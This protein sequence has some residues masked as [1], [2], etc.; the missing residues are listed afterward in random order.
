MTAW[1]IHAISWRSSLLCLL[2]AYA[3]MACS[4]PEPTPR[5]STDR[6]PNFIVIMADDQGYGEVGCFGS[7]RGT[8]PR[9]DRMAAEG[10]RFTQFYAAPACGPA[11]ASLLTGCYPNRVGLGFNNPRPDPEEAFGLNLQEITIAELLRER[12]YRTAIIGKW[13]MGEREFLPLNQGFDSFF[14]LPWSHGLYGPAAERATRFLN[15][16][17][18]PKT[19][20]YRDD[21]PIEFNP[22]I[23]TLTERYTEEAL[24]FLRENRERPFFLYLAQGMIHTPLAATRSFSERFA[25]PRDAAIAELDWSTGRILDTLVELGLEN[26]TLVIYT[27]DNGRPGP[28]E[29]LREGKGT[30]YEG[31]I[32]VPCVARWPSRIPAGETRSEIAS[33]MDLLP[34]LARL[35]GAQLPSD[36]VIDGKDIWPLISGQ[37]EAGPHEDFLYQFQDIV[38]AVRSGKWKLV[39]EGSVPLG[40]SLY[41]YAPALYDLEADLGESRDVRAEHPEIVRRLQKKIE[42]FKTDIAGHS[43]PIGVG[44]ASRPTRPAF[45]K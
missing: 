17:Y 25:D 22:D 39:L 37:Q 4:A 33:L 42:D 19:P 20:L 18:Y 2:F 36:R 13:H 35:A 21:E 1:F 6:P 12:G 43:R 14:G 41:N 38:L 10:V 44:K 32:R 5:G 28:N 9:I 8:T 31:G 40:P 11:R 15:P 29:P 16:P 27:S 24:R 45:V 23:A 30:V 3:L 26:D 7:L 34:T